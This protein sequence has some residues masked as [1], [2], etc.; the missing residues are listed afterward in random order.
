MPRKLV[1]KSRPANTADKNSL[2]LRNIVPLTDNQQK[3]P[4]QSIPRIRISYF[5]VWL[6]QVKHSVRCI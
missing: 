5:M 2:E 3:K 6:A 1:R 4:L